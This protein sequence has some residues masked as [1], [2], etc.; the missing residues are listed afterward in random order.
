MDDWFSI[1][2]KIIA[3]IVKE[4]DEYTIQ[5]IEKYVNGQEQQGNIVYSTVIC[6]GLLRHVI[7][8]GLKRLNELQVLDAK[9]HNL[10]Q[11]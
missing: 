6:E 7:N 1:A 5:I 4:S 3:N 10:F 2:G 9:H 8:L 11:Q